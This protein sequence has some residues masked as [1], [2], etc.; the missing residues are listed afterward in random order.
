MG[1]SYS[2]TPDSSEAHESCLRS[3]RNM[4]PP[5]TAGAP[6]TQGL[7]PR[8]PPKRSV[9]LRK[10]QMQRT[11]CALAAEAMRRVQSRAKT[12]T[13]APQKKKGKGLPSP[14]KK[15][16]G[17]P[18]PPKI[19]KG[20]PPPSNGIHGVVLPPPSIA[21]PTLMDLDANPAPHVPDRG[22]S[23]TE[24]E[25]SSQAGTSSPSVSK[26]QSDS[27]EGDEMPGTTL[28]LNDDGVLTDSD[29]C[30]NA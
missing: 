23:S 10:S 11:P 3:V 20:L 1:G 18:P 5:P 25:S 17:L 19:G 15:S 29:S 2:E 13:P 8:P 16:G 12:G 22:D 7:P 24:T 27:E 30:E 21:K 9:P 4:A 28:K 26:T 6:K 14:S